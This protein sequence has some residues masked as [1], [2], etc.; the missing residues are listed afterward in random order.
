MKKLLFAF[1]MI[2][3]FVSAPAWCSGL[4]E[5]KD[6]F[7]NTQSFTANFTQEVF[8]DDNKLMESSSGNFIIARPGRFRWHYESPSEQ[9]II[10]DGLQI[11][12][13][14]V[15]LEQATH[16]KSVDAIAGTPAMLL[17]GQGDLEEN[18]QLE[19]LESQQG[20]QRVRML[21]RQTD[22]GFTE[23]QAAFSDGLLKSILLRDSLG[24]T[25]RIILSNITEGIEIKENTFSFEPPEGVDIIREGE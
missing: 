9:L 25:T 22:A 24:H 15:E 7:D 6:F 14:D 4:D 2:A 20:M 10:G 17:S 21:P 23:I 19:E 5:L 13:Y 16:R 11:W 18:F 1:S 12:I 3:M 8:D